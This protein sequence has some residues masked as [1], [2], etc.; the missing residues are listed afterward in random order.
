MIL[1]FVAVFGWYLF[2]SIG[3]LK[4]DLNCSSN[5]GLSWADKVSTR[6][7]SFVS[8]ITNFVSP[9]AE[10]TKQSTEQFKMRLISY[11]IKVISRVTQK[12]LKY[13]NRTAILAFFV[14]PEARVF[15]VILTVYLNR[16]CSLILSFG[17]SMQYC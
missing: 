9:V 11:L 3:L 7:Q 17:S 1:S 12:L 15:A 14:L 4:A 2:Q 13:F 5:S 16:K 8:V 10:K 6:T